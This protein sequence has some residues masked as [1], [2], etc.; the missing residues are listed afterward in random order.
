MNLQ[1]I[2]RSI[3]DFKKKHRSAYAKVVEEETKGEVTFVELTIRFKVDN[4]K[5]SLEFCK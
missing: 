4:E 3:N 5:K 1:E 2:K